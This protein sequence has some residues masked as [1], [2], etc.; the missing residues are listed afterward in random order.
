M[1]TVRE[2]SLNGVLIQLKQAVWWTALASI[3]FGSELAKVLWRPHDDFYPFSILLWGAMAIVYF[4]TSRGALVRLTYAVELADAQATRI[5]TRRVLAVV[6]GIACVSFCF[7][8]SV[9]A[10]KVF[11]GLYPI[12]AVLLGPLLLFTGVLAHREIKRLASSLRP[13]RSF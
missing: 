12:A 5:K 1:T 9:V 6:F 3:Y 4:V 2:D 8:L 7:G 11:G 13:L 10:S